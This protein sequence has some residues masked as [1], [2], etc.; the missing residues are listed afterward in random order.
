ME[1]NRR[2]SARTT[3]LPA[4][5]VTDGTRGR[6]LD[7]ALRLFAEGGFAGASIRDIATA[8]GVQSATLYAHFPG[9]EHV[10]A[11]LIRLGHDEHHRRLRS[12][13]LDSG[14][15]P[16]D[17]LGALTRAHVRTH[18]DFPMLSMIANSELH[19]LS[20]ELAAPVIA[21]RD[22]STQLFLDVAQRGIDRGE[23]APPDLWLA[24]AAI[25]GMGIR[26]ASWFGPDCGYDAEQVADTY[27]RFALGIMGSGRPEER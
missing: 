7:A 20:P 25:G 11:E 21:V 16:R 23:F 19:A 5:A 14:P 6:I 4:A 8:A 17:Q 3:R 26:V 15:D 9:K 24:V 10:L 12:A 18:T 1:G 22:S 2:L 27:A 13:L